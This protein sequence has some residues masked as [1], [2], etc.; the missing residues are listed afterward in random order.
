MS[1]IDSQGPLK[2]K[3]EAEYYTWYEV[4]YFGKI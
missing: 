1:L 2:S 4:L 3:L